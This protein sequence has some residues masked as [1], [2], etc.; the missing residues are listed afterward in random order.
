MQR[1]DSCSYCVSATTRLRP[2]SRLPRQH[3]ALLWS[4]A[5]TLPVHVTPAEKQQEEEEEGRRVEDMDSTPILSTQ[6]RKAA[7]IADHILVEPR[8]E[9]RQIEDKLKT[10]LGRWRNSTVVRQEVVA[11]CDTT[12]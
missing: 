8:G 10:A 7:L 11:L 3:A 1:G 6:G 5:T 2:H 4:K 12:P 9:G